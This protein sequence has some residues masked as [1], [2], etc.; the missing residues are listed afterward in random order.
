MCVCVYV[1]CAFALSADIRE[2]DIFDRPVPPVTDEQEHIMD[3]LIENT[4]FRYQPR[5]FEDPFLCQFFANLESVVFDETHN[6]HKDMSMPD[7]WRLEHIIGELEPLLVPAFG[8]DVPAPASKRLASGRTDDD[9]AEASSAPKSAKGTTSGGQV[10]LGIDEMR[11]AMLSGTAD[12]LTAAML[13]G[14][15]LQFTDLKSLSKVKKQDLLDLV[16]QHC[17]QV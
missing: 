13:R 17:G 16:R 9:S 5:M 3:N 14:F 6:V 15:L 4:S 10:V 2:L 8:E 1:T 7:K 11:R 12:R